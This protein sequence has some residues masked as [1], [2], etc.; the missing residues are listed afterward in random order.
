MR[1]RTRAHAGHHRVLEVGGASV[2]TAGALHTVFAEIRPTALPTAD[3]RDLLAHLSAAAEAGGLFGAELPGTLYDVG[4]R[5]GYE[6]ALK[7]LGVPE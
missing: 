5:A 7:H 4:T 1:V 6:H 3:D 2:P